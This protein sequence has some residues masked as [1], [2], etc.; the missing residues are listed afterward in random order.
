MNFIFNRSVDRAISNVLTLIAAFLPIIVIHYYGNGDIHLN[1][2]KIFATLEQING[3]KSIL[4]LSGIG[5]GF[6]Y[7]WDEISKRLFSFIGLEQ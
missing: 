1:S 5:L 2:A 6:I 3:L 4:N 7:Q